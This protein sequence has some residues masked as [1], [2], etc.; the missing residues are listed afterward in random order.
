MHHLLTPLPLVVAGLVALPA[1]APVPVVQ[2]P[3]LSVQAD[4]S[5]DVYVPIKYF[6]T[7]TEAEAVAQHL[8][9]ERPTEWMEPVRRC[10]RR[11]P[12]TRVRQPSRCRTPCSRCTCRRWCS[13]RCRTLP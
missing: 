1:A 9:T 4:R 3:E 11:G 10:A 5:G 12:K 8:D 13:G 6:S 2:V 7:V